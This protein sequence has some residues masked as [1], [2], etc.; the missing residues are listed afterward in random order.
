VRQTSVEPDD[1]A[2]LARA[3]DGVAF[4]AVCEVL[5]SAERGAAFLGRYAPLFRA[6]AEP[7]SA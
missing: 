6:E 1:A 7:I 4:G 2:L 5:A 3:R